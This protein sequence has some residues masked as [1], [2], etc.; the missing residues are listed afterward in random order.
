MTHACCPACHLRLS[1][2]DAASLSACPSCG[3]PLTRR[4][5]AAFALGYRLFER[6]AHRR[7]NAQEM[8]LEAVEAARAAPPEQTPP[9]FTDRGPAPPPGGPAG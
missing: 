3:G 9:G 1:G 8:L 6:T 5:S 7:S 2:A 4:H